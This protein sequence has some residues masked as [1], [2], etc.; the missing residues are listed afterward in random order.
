MKFSENV[1]NQKRNKGENKTYKI[2]LVK[3]N[4]FE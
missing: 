4:S 3:N 1:N 2:S